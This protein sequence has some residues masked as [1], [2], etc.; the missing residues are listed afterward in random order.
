MTLREYLLSTALL[1]E[2]PYLQPGLRPL[3]KIVR[4]DTSPKLVNG[5]S[6]NGDRIFCHICGGHRHQRGITA[7]LSDGSLIL[8][9]RHCAEKFF[10]PKIWERCW[11]EFKRKQE[12]AFAR[13][14]ILNLRKLCQPMK[15][16]FNS[17]RK[18]V[19]NVKEV[20]DQISVAHPNFVSELEKSLKRNN[21]RIVESDD[22][23]VSSDTAEAGHRQS[24]FTTTIV[25]TVRGG[26]FLPHVANIDKDLVVVE[27]FLTAIENM[28][29]DVSDQVILEYSKR[30][31]Q[32]VRM[33]AR[34]IDGTLDLTADLFS[35]AKLVTIGAW[36][37]RRRIR[38]L[39]H[40]PRVTP[41]DIAA[42]IRKIC[43][44]GYEVPHSR[45]EETIPNLRKSVAELSAER[46]S[47]SGAI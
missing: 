7:Q 29:E 43:G 12:V 31:E 39:R 37:D 1:V 35:E 47:N 14:R 42:S 41:R 45:L 34:R 13:Y 6:I 20:W 33:S 32:N 2:S 9:G 46:P 22:V 10:G 24:Y 19:L 26:E 27:S 28:P 38:E 8:F 4:P 21:N 11:G 5:Y 18:Q 17:Y 16:W 15:N 23:T 25:A 3:E 36:S 30:L 40:L 44:H